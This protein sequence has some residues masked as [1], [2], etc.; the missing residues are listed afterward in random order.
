MVLLIHRHKPVQVRIRVNNVRCYTVVP[1]TFPMGHCKSTTVTINFI[2][3]TLWNAGLKDKVE[4][5]HKFKIEVTDV[6]SGVLLDTTTHGI[7]LPP[8]GD[9]LELEIE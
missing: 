7:A 6:E 1:H 8:L 3:P 4:A 5:Q 9:L 2:K